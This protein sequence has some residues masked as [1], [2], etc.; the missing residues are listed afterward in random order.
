M[1]VQV[2]GA[3]RRAGVVA[4]VLVAMVSLSACA[5]LPFMSR[6]DS[7]SG[8][9][10]SAGAATQSPQTAP[11]GQEGL[12]R[13]YGQSLR[14]S[15]CSGGQCAKLTVPVDYANPSGPTIE[16]A[17]LKVPASDS[18]QRVGSLVVNPGGPGASGVEY[19]RG[20]SHVVSPP[21]RR[22]YDIVGF[23]PRGVGASA[24][25]DCLSDQDLDQ[26]LGMDPTPDTAGEAQA[27][28][29]E[30]KK[31]ADGCA[32][33]GG[34]LLAHLST[35]EVARDMDVL[36]AALGESQLNYLGKSYGT[37]IGSTYADLFAKNVGRFVLDGVVA[38]D[39]TSAELSEGQARG[40]ELATRAY[41]ATCVKNP[42]CPAGSSVDEGMQWLRDFLKGVDSQPLRVTSD[43][44]VTQLGEGWAT[45]G[46]GY[47]MYAQQLWPSLTSALRDAKNGDG[48]A[49]MELADQYADRSASGAY[50]DNL[51]EVI[52][53]VNC[54]DK[55]DTADLT[56]VQK[57]ADAFAQVAPTWGRMLAWGSVPCGV[58]PVQSGRTPKT[59]SAAGSNPIVVVGTTRD[60]ATIYEWSVRLR[61]Q[62]SNA[63]LI[64]YDGDG[65][66][67][68]RRSNSCVDNAIDD[69]YL[70]GDVPKDGLTC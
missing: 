50:A 39:L 62:L 55:P 41:M 27:F 63:A 20:A 7:G 51:M 5:A 68:Y 66:T 69:Y 30:A 59:V 8:A 16:L 38:P 12:A 53:A 54:L 10:G 34:A 32:R 52:Y 6:D 67:A 24:P 2:R 42:S 26:F 36:R 9:T 70:N 49:L 46:I 1:S 19:A 18:G 43:A 64:T 28:L 61:K 22:Q 29:A 35:E 47:A 11:A 58:W 17:L 15:S 57:N 23:D 25:L 60:P 65:H 31:L 13:F 3:R 4:A 37:Y 14:W 56:A 21:V 40:F 48:T 45:M 33:G 44:R